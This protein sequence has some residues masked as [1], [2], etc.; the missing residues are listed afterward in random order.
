M[1]LFFFVS[2]LHLLKSEPVRRLCIV[3]LRI[4]PVKYKGWQ[5]PASCLCEDAYH[6]KEPRSS[7][8][9]YERC[10]SPY[11][12]RSSPSDTVPRSRCQSGLGRWFLN[13]DRGV[14]RMYA[15]AMLPQDD[16]K[17]LS[18]TSSAGRNNL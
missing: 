18:W 11:R 6:Q 7:R 13:R 10:D 4:I 2:F 17:A 14:G 9:L 15:S 5:T 16:V 3:E 8:K 12:R 1:M